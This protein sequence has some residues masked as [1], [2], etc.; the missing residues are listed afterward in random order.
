MLPGLFPLGAGSSRVERT[1][2][3]GPIN[4]S[5]ATTYTFTAASLGTASAD[6]HLAIFVCSDNGDSSYSLNSITV[7][8]TDITSS[9]ADSNQ[10]AAGDFR[11][12]LFVVA[13]PT[14][15]S[16]NVVVT[17]SEAISGCGIVIYALTGLKSTTL[18]DVA[19]PIDIPVSET[20][21]VSSGGVVL[22][23]AFEL[24]DS[25]TATAWSFTAGVTADD[26]SIVGGSFL[27]GCASEEIMGANSS[28]SVQWDDNGTSIAGTRV[29]LIASLR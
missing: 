2:T 18:V 6:R 10:V 22:A 29:G 21:S 26:D 20:I 5:D 17:F 4:N 12:N 13:F 3:A 8:G 1:F 19:K 23:C 24:V 7:A 27:M 11:I 9:L 25:G 16:G 14:G 15:T 28:Y